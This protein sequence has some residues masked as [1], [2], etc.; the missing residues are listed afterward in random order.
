MK[1]PMVLQMCNIG[2]KKALGIKGGWKCQ[3]QR[4]GLPKSVGAQMLPSQVLDTGS[5]VTKSGLH[6]WISVLLSPIFSVR[7]FTLTYATAYCVY[8]Y[9][10]S[11]VSLSRAQKRPWTLSFWTLLGLFRQ[12]RLLHLDWT[13][14]AR[15][16]H[17]PKGAGHNVRVWVWNVLHRFMCLN[18]WATAGAVRRP[19]DL[20]DLVPHWQMKTTKAEPW[21]PPVLLCL[22]A[23]LLPCE[24]TL[25][26]HLPTF[27]QRAVPSEFK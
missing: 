14:F 12:W 26:S 15:N 5:G 1:T 13:K 24:E 8:I 4:R 20:W 11:Q 10:G 19:W 21:Q 27:L 23:C 17:V 7:M 6:F 22:S 2:W 16:C 9:N 25:I 3:G 18:I